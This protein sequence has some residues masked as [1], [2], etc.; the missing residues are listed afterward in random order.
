MFLQATSQIYPKY[1]RLSLVVSSEI[2]F[3]MIIVNCAT[4]IPHQRPLGQLHVCQ[5]L[6]LQIPSQKL[7]QL[8]HL[9]LAIQHCPAYLAALLL[10]HAPLHRPEDPAS[11]SIQPQPLIIQ[12]GMRLV[13]LNQMNF[14]FVR[15]EE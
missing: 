6:Q 14:N 5:T 4:T 9:H 12:L 10:L 8:T 15:Q 2:T 11:N 7:I 3:M 13:Y 1:W